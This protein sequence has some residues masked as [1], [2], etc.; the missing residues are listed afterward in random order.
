[1]SELESARMAQAQS[2]HKYT[3]QTDSLN[4]RI[5]ELTEA[6]KDIAD[7]KAKLSRK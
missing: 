3:L 7:L 5:G 6:R 2:G 4:Q 1:M